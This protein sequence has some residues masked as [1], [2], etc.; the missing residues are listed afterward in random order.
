MEKGG[1][2][3]K[4]PFASLLTSRRL[5]AVSD[6]LASPSPGQGIFPWGSGEEGVLQGICVE[7]L[8]THLCFHLRPWEVQ[9]VCPMHRG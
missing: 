1:C 6:V 7:M 4:F 2:L 3:V 8:I 9:Q 5:G